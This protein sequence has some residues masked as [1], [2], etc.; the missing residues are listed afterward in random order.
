MLGGAPNGLP[1]PIEG[2]RLFVKAF[3]RADGPGFTIDPQ[4]IIE[5]AQQMATQIRAIDVKFLQTHSLS[6]QVS[7]D[8]FA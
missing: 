8:L 1:V 3:A 2:K 5:L 7:V 6:L 4:I